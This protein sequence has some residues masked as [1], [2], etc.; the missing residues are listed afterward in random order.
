MMEREVT[1]D[2]SDESWTGEKVILSGD[3]GGTNANLA[4]VTKCEKGFRLL[5]EVSAASLDL[6]SI[7]RL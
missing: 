6:D 5:L 1:V 7:S 4:L 3:I 2:W